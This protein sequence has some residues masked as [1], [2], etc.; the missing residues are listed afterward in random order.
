MENQITCVFQLSVKNGMLDY[1]KVLV[2]KVVAATRKEVGTLAYFYSVD[3]SGQIVHIIEQ[4]TDSLALVSHIDQTFA[5]FADDF[6]SMVDIRKLTVYGNP[7]QN[8]K[9]RLDNFGAM[10][11]KPFD[12]FI[13]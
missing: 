2:E 3:Q 11:L 4:Y 9:L 7:D 10:Y 12:G 6:I 13:G 5:P 8:A 1:F